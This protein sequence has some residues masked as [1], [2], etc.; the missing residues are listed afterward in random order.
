VRGLLI[1]VSCAMTPTV[2]Y[3]HFTGTI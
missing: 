2:I 3:K 1:T